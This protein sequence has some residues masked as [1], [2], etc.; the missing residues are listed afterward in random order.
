MK[1]KLIIAGRQGLVLNSVKAKVRFILHPLGIKYFLQILLAQ[2]PRLHYY[3]HKQ[4]YTD[5]I[6]VVLL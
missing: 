5:Y 2:T 4:T 6:I 3:T 1:I